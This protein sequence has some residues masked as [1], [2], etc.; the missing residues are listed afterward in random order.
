MRLLGNCLPGMNTCDYVLRSDAR[1][2][3]YHNIS[4]QLVEARA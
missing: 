4:A 2:A 1:G 3:K